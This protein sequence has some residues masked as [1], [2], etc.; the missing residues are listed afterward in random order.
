MTSSTTLT[1]WREG[2][3][4]SSPAE[5][6]EKYP[7]QLSGGVR[8]RVAMAQAVI[9]NPE[10]LLMDEPFGALDDA[11]RQG[12]AELPPRALGEERDD[13]PAA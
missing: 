2:N 8:Q 13:D 11:T 6:G 10:I 9:M 12:G 3:R 7:H 1:R 5:E 4:P